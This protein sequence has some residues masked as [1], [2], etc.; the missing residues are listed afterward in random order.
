[1][2]S[3]QDEQAVPFQL[4]ESPDLEVGFLLEY[5]EPFGRNLAEALAVLSMRD[6]QW[7]VAFHT[8]QGHDH[9]NSAY[10]VARTLQSYYLSGRITESTTPEELAGLGFFPVDAISPMEATRVADTMESSYGRALGWGDGPEARYLGTLEFGNGTVR[11]GQIDRLNME[12]R[13]IE[14]Q[15]VVE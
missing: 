1:M 5:I 3:G 8:H 4:I 14:L 9:L 10:A 6:D 12:H 13:T 2:V 15:L 11:I 7:I